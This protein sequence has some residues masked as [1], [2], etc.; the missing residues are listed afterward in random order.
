MRARRDFSP[1]LALMTRQKIS[2]ILYRGMKPFESGVL[3]RMT[4]IS[5]VTAA[6]STGWPPRR[7]A[8]VTRGFGTRDAFIIR[9][10][11]YH[12]VACHLTVPRGI[13][14]TR[15]GH[16]PTLPSP[17]MLSNITRAKMKAPR[18]FYA[19]AMR[20]LYAHTR[21]AFSRA[22]AR[23]PTPRDS[24][25]RPPRRAAAWA[26][27]RRRVS[28]S[29]DAAPRHF[30]AAGKRRRFIFILFRQSHALAPRIPPAIAIARQARADFYMIKPHGPLV[31]NT[32]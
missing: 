27:C 17:F 24:R 11:H 4:M 12:E 7:D 19:L 2:N 9:R 21:W 16:G 29:R 22:M 6:T 5:R 28:I 15:Q 20:M 23:F 14:A 32:T 1:I 10:R 25:H 3:P 8:R 13:E 26:T 31:P 18:T 30:I